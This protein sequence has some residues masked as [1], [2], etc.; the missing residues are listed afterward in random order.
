M[1]LGFKIASSVSPPIFVD[2]HADNNDLTE[3]MVE[4]AKELGKEMP[5]IV[6]DYL[7]GEIE[8]NTISPE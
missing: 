7:D 3:K 4:K 1:D 2:A 8:S 5:F 6:I